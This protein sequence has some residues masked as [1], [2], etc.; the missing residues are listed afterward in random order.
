MAAAAAAA[1]SPFLNGSLLIHSLLGA[2]AGI[3]DPVSPPLHPAA[4]ASAAFSPPGDLVS[5]LS[6]P[7]QQ[8]PQS[9]RIPNLASASE[10]GAA[11]TK[12]SSIADL[13]LKA[14]RHQEAI[15][16]SLSSLSDDLDG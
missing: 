3:T 14:R 16:R 1:S 6:Q 7:P 10:A 5:R 8:A 11:K 15:L 2:A 13:R 9:A 4:A 12:S